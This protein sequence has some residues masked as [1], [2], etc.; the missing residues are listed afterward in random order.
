MPK[1][2]TSFCILCQKK[3]STSLYGITDYLYC[4]N[5]RLAWLKEYADITYDDT[6]YEGTSGTAGKM[7]SPIQSFFYSI[8][9]SFAHKKIVK[10]WIDV[11]AGDGKY[12]E[13]V[14][15]KRR[16]GV[17][18]SKS[19]RRIMKSHGLETMTDSVFLKTRNL[20]ADVISFWQVLEHVDKPLDYLIAAQR[21]LKANGTIIVAVPNHE[22]FEFKTFGKYWFHLVPQFHIWHFSEFSLRHLIEKAH[23]KVDS[24][25]YWAIEHHFTGVL[26]SFI[27]RS[28]KS[29]SVLHRII[30]RR[31]DF[32]SLS[33]KDIFWVLFWCTIGLPVVVLFWIAGALFHKSGTFVMVLSKAK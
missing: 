20:Q 14:K 31:Q 7:F 33:P 5:D 21:N 23:M 17:E 24:M 1:K 32:A 12:L 3:S 10:L 30:K 16:I 26:Q 9:N 25:D 15:A 13:S 18:I 29:D 27:N 4:K 28:A 19:G 22:S 8:R 11:G 2:R 6:Y